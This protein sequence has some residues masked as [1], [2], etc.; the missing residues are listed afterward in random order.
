MP[1]SFFL[2][3]CIRRG[4]N[5]VIISNVTLLN[6]YKPKKCMIIKRK[7]SGFLM[8]LFVV[9]LLVTHAQFVTPGWTWCH[10]N[11]FFFLYSLRHQNLS[12]SCRIVMSRQ[13]GVKS[14]DVPLLPSW[15]APGPEAVKRWVRKHCPLFILSVSSTH[16]HSWF[17]LTSSVLYYL[18]IIF[19]LF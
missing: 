3:N 5:S 17:D 6:Y 19:P 14:V 13:T 11:A 1:L 4:K 2:Q 9:H 16:Q 15:T 8:H 7:C 18:I 10:T 12:R